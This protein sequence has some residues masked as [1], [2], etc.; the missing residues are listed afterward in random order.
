MGTI[1][2]SALNTSILSFGSPPGFPGPK[3]ASGIIG[4]PAPDNANFGGGIPRMN[5]SVFESPI[6]PPSRRSYVRSTDPN[7]NGAGRF[8]FLSFR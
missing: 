3:R 8:N 7:P 5:V 4:S 2:K 1:K 6:A